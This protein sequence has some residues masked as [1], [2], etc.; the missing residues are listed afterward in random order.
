LNRLPDQFKA[1]FKGLAWTKLWHFGRFD[2]NGC[3]S[4]WIATGACS[5]LGHCKCSKSNQG[6]CAALFNVVQTAP[7]AWSPGRGRQQLSEMSACLAM[8]SINSVLFI[9]RA[10]EKNRSLKFQVITIVKNFCF[11]VSKLPDN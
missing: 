2:F 10:L 7:M 5:A 11:E 9:Q 6:N 4:A 8:C 3:A 1:S